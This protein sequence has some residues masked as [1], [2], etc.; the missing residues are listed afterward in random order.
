[1]H[2]AENPLQAVEAVCIDWGGTLMSEDGPDDVPMA[3]WPTVHVF[4]DAEPCLRQIAQVAPLAV[5]TNATVSNR[6]M[7]EKALDRVGLLQY[8]GSI[9]C[10]T[11]MGARKSDRDFWEHVSHALGAP[12]DRIA[13]VGDSIEQ[14]AV[15]PRR[16]GV[17]GVWLDRSGQGQEGHL[18]VPAVRDL[19]MFASWVEARAGQ[20]SPQADSVGMAVGADIKIRPYHPA[21]P[22][23][24][25]K[26]R[27]ELVSALSPSMVLAVEHVGSTSVP[28]LPA[29]PIVDILV[30]VP[31][32][33]ESAA[34]IP[35]M[36]ALGFEHRPDDELPDRHYFA[37]TVGGLRRHHVSFAEPESTCARNTV[38]FRNALRRDPHLAQRY[39]DLKKGLA[40]AVGT[41]RLDYLNGKT[42][43][44]LG[45]L[46]AEGVLIGDGYPTRYVGS[47]GARS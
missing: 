26:V 42:A 31:S 28:G 22:R 47:R 20:T 32:L 21:W 19:R 9:F 25:A 1:M 2:S 23:E 36:Q 30:T 15:F 35:A 33:E 18:D 27:A 43:F 11:E 8:I 39:A 5:A 38:T 6:Q 46:E 24:F 37:R 14:D 3:L 41:R 10:F 4:E 29:K 12:L 45:V 34:L 7:V 40:A 44:I 13:M 16:Y 17:Q